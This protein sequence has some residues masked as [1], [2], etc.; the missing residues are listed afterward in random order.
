MRLL[1]ETA[2]L[3]PQRCSKALQNSSPLKELGHTC[4]NTSEPNALFKGFGVTPPTVQGGQ[5]GARG[6]LSKKRTT[7][8]AE[9]GG[10]A[11]SE[12][13]PLRVSYLKAGSG[14]RWVMRQ[15]GGIK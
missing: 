9:L 7:S 3:I 4:P 5:L 11:S 14:I 8:P 1:N 2:P 10:F 13:K 15:N 12:A 6:R